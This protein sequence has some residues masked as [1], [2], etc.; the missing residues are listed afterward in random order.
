MLQTRQQQHA[1]WQNNG[2]HLPNSTDDSVPSP[3]L[4]QAMNPFDYRLYRMNWLN[5]RPLMQ[6][7][8]LILAIP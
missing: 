2:V 4:N 1:F 8:R 3:V 5:S 6:V 7:H